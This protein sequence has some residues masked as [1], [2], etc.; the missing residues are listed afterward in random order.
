M[1]SACPANS[2]TQWME[3]R[4]SLTARLQAASSDFAVRV[5]RQELGS[6]NEDEAE[7][8][9]VR[10]GQRAWVREV[11]LLCDGLPVV[12]AHSVTPESA[13]HGAWRVIVDVGGKSLGSALFNDFEVARSVMQ[14][15]LIS[16][17]HPLYLQAS[18][19]LG[20]FTIPLWARRSCF[21]REQTPLLVTEMFL[22]QILTLTPKDTP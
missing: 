9:G 4:D 21:V 18:S 12:F 20:K 22:P 13:I 14:Y 2:Y 19:C 7:V 8:I 10:K 15:C 6:P 17:S 3:D 16:E 11:V 5:I 1:A